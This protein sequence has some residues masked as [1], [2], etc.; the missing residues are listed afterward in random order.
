MQHS[1]DR[2]PLFTALHLAAALG[3]MAIFSG[4]SAQA[5]VNFFDP[6]T[7]TAASL[8]AGTFTTSAYP[9]GTTDA[10][11]PTAGDVTSPF[12]MA[13]GSNTLTFT[14]Q[15]PVPNEASFGNIDNSGGTYDIS[16]NRLIETADLVTLVPTGPLQIDF[17][18]GVT[19]FGLNAEDFSAV[20]ESFTVTAYNNGTQ[21]GSFT[22]PVVDSSGANPGKSLFLGGKTTN[23]DLITQLVISS[24]ST[25][26]DSM[27]GVQTDTGDSNDFVFGPVTV[28]NQSGAPVPEAST[29]VSSGFGLLLFGGLFFWS[30]RKR[31]AAKA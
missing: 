9:A 31:Q 4:P 20:F 22:T 2:K 11:D 13:A 23:G 15:N 1:N 10:I 8:G 27:T 30:S 17:Q 7:D 21:I 5:G 18:Q 19:G 24:T 12:S 26:P 14:A 16:S 29:V 25:L 6:Q 28:A 3:L